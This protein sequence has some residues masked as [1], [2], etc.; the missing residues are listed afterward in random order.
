MVQANL[1]Y[2]PYTTLTLINL[3]RKQLKSMPNRAIASKLSRKSR[4]QFKKGYPVYLRQ[5]RDLKIRKIT[6]SSVYGNADITKN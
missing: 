4:D 5:K 1:I 3:T 6:M 2:H